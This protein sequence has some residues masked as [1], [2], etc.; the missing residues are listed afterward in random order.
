[1]II[2]LSIIIIVLFFCLVYL[3]YYNKIHINLLSENKQLEQK[4]KI[5]NTEIEDLN[6]KKNDLKLDIDNLKY[7]QIKIRESIEDLSENQNTLKQAIENQ[8]ELSEKAFN[9]YYDMLEK[10]YDEAEQEHNME[11]D[12]LQNAYSDLQLKLM[13][14]A[15]ECR[16]DLDKL[17]TTRAAALEAQKKEREIEEQQSFY[18]LQ[19][20]DADLK[21]VAILD[22]VKPKLNNPRILSMLIWQTFYR[23][24]MTTLCNNV[25]G[26]TVKTGI[27][28]ITNQLT[29]ECYIGQAVDIASRWKDHAKAG[30]GIDTPQRNKLY[31]AMI[32]YG[33]QN[34]SWEI[35][36]ECS[37]ENLDKKEKF[38]INLYQSKEFGYNTQAGN[39]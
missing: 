1:M 2:V 6:I 8:T 22:T 26:T 29:K 39:N 34:F 25:V 28:K 15:D 32:E 7:D 14:E 12:A 11:M 9:S 4:N 38:Y 23:T 17:R 31:K 21:D 19:I 37:K 24:P 30:L 18:C 35:L 16:Q 5:L 27:Y 13:R 33:I 36:E 20:K 3:I 10:R